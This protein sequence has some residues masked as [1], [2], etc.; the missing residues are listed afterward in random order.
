[1][2]ILVTAWQN[3]T[4]EWWQTHR[5]RFDIYISGIVLAEA[6]KGDAEA[7]QKRLETIQQ[8]PLLEVNDTVEGLS[9]QLIE[10]GILPPKA[11]DDALH[12]SVASVHGVDYLLTW[13]CRHINN[14]ENK[15]IIRSFLLSKGFG[16]PEICTPQELLGGEE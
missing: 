8:I 6:R 1:M 11:Q 4:W 10:T 5:N 2:N 13:N 7:A 15:P 12:I 9:R 3:V 14:A 16:C